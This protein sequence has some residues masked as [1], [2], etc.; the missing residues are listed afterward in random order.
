MCLALIL[1]LLLGWGLEGSLVALVASEVVIG[2]YLLIGTKIHSFIKPRCFSTELLKELLKYSWPMVPNC[3]SMWAMRMSNRLVI[4]AIM[5]VAAN[6]VFAA[7]FKIP[8][9]ITIAQTTFT[10]AWQENASLSVTDGDKEA[11]YTHTQALVFD[12]LAGSAAL[13]IAIT[14]VLYALL[15]QGDYSEGLCQVPI[16]VLGNLFYGMSAYIGGI[17]VAYLKTKSVGLTTFFAAII[18]LVIDIVFIPFVGLYAASIAYVVSY[19]FLWIYRMVD[20]Q[21]FQ[22]LGLNV[23][24]YV[25]V[26]AILACMVFIGQFD[27][28]VPQLIN[29]AIGVVVFFV[30]CRKVITGSFKMIVRRVKH[31]K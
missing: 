25:I 29:G 2:G 22:S 7:A 19:L 11:Y 16:L 13:L 23:P 10:M 30:L 15:I 20:V 28:I 21:K 5:G 18:N 14:P 17:Y 8:Q 31:A 26:V 12:F 1:V 9:L 27:G 24:R 3:M 6:A 4:T